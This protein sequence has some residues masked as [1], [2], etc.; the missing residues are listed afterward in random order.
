M[1]QH[2]PSWH[3]IR[4]RGHYCP[5]APDARSISVPPR[6]PSSALGLGR[7]A[8]VRL[9]G[10]ARPSCFPMPSTNTTTH[11][12]CDLRRVRLPP[13]GL[14]REPQLSLLY[15]WLAALPHERRAMPSW[16][17]LSSPLHGPTCGR[18]PMPP[19]GGRHRF[20]PNR[21]LA[22]KYSTRLQTSLPSTN[23]S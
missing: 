16:P 5:S 2:A 8:A 10:P 11:P 19:S 23:R 12:H 22:A 17:L 18:S 13:P 1:R 6:I 7:G 20:R 4:R 14:L 21:V 15:L 9:Q 3:T